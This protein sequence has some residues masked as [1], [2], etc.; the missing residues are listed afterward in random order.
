[1]R[2]LVEQVTILN[3]K[4]E[5]QKDQQEAEERRR[6]ELAEERQHEEEMMEEQR[7]S[8]ARQASEQK[9][10]DAILGALQLMKPQPLQITPPSYTTTNCDPTF[11]GGMTCYSH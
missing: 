3:T 6:S 2:D 5:H 8:T 7:A 1:M 11:G 10:H 4:L 9:H